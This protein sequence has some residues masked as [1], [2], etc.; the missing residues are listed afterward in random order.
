MN[1]NGIGMNHHGTHS[2]GHSNA[3]FNNGDSSYSDSDGEMQRGRSIIGRRRRIGPR[4]TTSTSVTTG[5]AQTV[6]P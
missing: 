1:R 6:L 3:G 5:S 2:I 4:K